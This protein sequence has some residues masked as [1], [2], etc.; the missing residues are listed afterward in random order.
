MSF[1]TCD[2]CEQLLLEE[3]Q[4]KGICEECEEKDE[5]K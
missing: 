3:E 1:Y 5:E 2:K 4:E